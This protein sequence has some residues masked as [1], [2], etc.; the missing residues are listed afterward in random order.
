MKKLFLLIG[1]VFIFSGCKDDNKYFISDG[2]IGGKTK[3]YIKDERGCI[4]FKSCNR[5]YT[6]CNNYYIKDLK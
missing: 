3:S 1:L 5:N 6:M 2:E 4:H